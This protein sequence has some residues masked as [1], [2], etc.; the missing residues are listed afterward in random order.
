MEKLGFQRCLDRALRS[1]IPV[2]VVVTDRLTGIKALMRNEYKVH[3]IEHQVDVWHLCKNI[4]SK[5]ATKAKKKECE[6]L[7]P[8]LTASSVI[9]WRK[10]AP[11]RLPQGN[12]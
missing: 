1:G 11:L 9:E 3:G 6:A 5:L 4:K 10:K 2:E 8:W 12:E 7:G